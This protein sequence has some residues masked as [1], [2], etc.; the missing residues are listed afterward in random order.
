MAFFIQHWCLPGGYLA[1]AIK[2]CIDY[3]LKFA[4]NLYVL[5]VFLPTNPLAY[6]N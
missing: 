5:P 6:Y 3:E 2:G 1:Q 4:D